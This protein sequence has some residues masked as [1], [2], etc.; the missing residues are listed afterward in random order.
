[1]KDNYFDPNNQFWI[2][3]YPHGIPKHLDYPKIPLFKFLDN[4]AEK[5]PDL[6]ALIFYGKKISY[7][8]L[9]NLSDRFA[10]FLQKIG[11]KKG[12]RVALFLPNCPQFVIAYFGIL[13]AGGVVVPLNPLYLPQELNDIL[14]DAKPKI[15]I[16]LKLLSS[17][18]KYIRKKITPILILSDLVDYIPLPLKFLLKIKT[19]LSSSVK[20]NFDGYLFN[21]EK[22][23]NQYSGKGKYQQVKFTPSDLA[24]LIYT[25]GTTGKPKG[26]KL[27]HQNLVANLVQ[28]NTW[29]KDI[30]MVGQDI[31]LGVL[32]FF[33]VYGITAALNFAI[34]SALS[35][36]LFPEFHSNE[37]AKAISKYRI[38]LVPAV[39]IMLT[40]VLQRYQEN[41]PKY[42]F[43]TV[44]L[45]TTGSEFCEPALIENLSQFNGKI[46]EGYGLSETSPIVT[47]NPYNKP[48]IGS[49]GLPLP[50]T[51]CR[52]VD[53][54]TG[55]E[56]PVGEKGELLVKGP[57]VFSS[58]WNNPEATNKAFDTDGWFHTGDIAK[59]DKEGYIFM[60]GR[61]D[62]IINVGGEK[63][64]P[65]KIEKVIKKYPGVKDVAVVGL[66]D[67]YFGEIPV[68][69]VVSTKERATVLKQ[70]LPDFCRKFL[71]SY[72][73]PRKIFLV[74]QIPKSHIG[75]T[76]YRQLRKETKKKEIAI[77][78]PKDIQEVPRLVRNL[79]NSFLKIFIFP[80]IRLIWV[81][82]VDG[83]NYIP[84]KGGFVIA[85]N[86]ESFFDFICFRAAFSREVRY[87]TAAKFFREWWWSPIVTLTGQIKVER[88]GPNRK[89]S[90]KKAL[91]QAI[92]LLKQ[93]EIIGI[94]PEGTRSPE[95]K[96]LHKAFTGVARMAL[97]A[98]VPVIP[99]GMIGTYEIMSRYDKYPHLKKCQIKVGKPMFFNQY[100][101][102]EN[103]QDVLEYITTK[104]M[105][106]IS[107]LTGKPYDFSSSSHNI[108]K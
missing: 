41:F 42:D 57:Q 1:M 84:T 12:D 98:K 21:F 53:W 99:V 107:E 31:E 19:Y 32:P 30:T 55:K 72:M 64:S 76:L 93:G 6:T 105:L 75:K 89:E 81:G 66:P 58:Y 13:K 71:D 35:L 25:S 15:L 48:K 51:N 33:H 10:E 90:A 67:P 8:K 78:P 50:D 56:V 96:R 40:V 4:S 11:I 47:M 49:I 2:K 38:T 62:D 94:F 52:I 101:G 34:A 28:I 95:G 73:V 45:W 65:S 106:K 17:K 22:L 46:I 82:Q 14:I 86:H 69:Y 74:D 36:V 68:A 92:S 29:L 83:I 97:I 43:S 79:T 39:P 20:I 24:L 103:N 108:I 54:E 70:E 80:F 100:Y 7:K 9:K 87:L 3:S 91:A 61:I 26:V 60:E 77:P 102:Q 59:Q 27:T 88:Y 104:I 85:F 37:I 23:L 63:V 18:L 44:R 16:S 5:F